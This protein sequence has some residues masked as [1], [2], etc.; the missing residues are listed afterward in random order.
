MLLS[1]APPAGKR[2]P[3]ALTVS[4]EIF[5]GQEPANG[6]KPAEQK[7]QR[8]GKEKEEEEEEKEREAV[9]KEGKDARFQPTFIPA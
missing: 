9:T 2:I 6:Q 8:G 3:S 4:R 1:P 5:S 7:S